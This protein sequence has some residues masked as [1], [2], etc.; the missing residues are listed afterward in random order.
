[1][2][3]KSQKAVPCRRC[4]HR[5]CWN[6]PLGNWPPGWPSLSVARKLRNNLHLEG[7][8]DSRIL[9]LKDPG[10][11]KLRMVSWNLN[12]PTRLGGD[13]TPQ[14]HPLTFG[15][16]SNAPSK[17]GHVAGVVFYVGKGFLK[18][19]VRVALFFSRI[20][21]FIYCMEIF[22][23]ILCLYLYLQLICCHC[24]LGII[25]RTSA[26]KKGRHFKGQKP[27]AFSIF[28]VLHADTWK[29]FGMIFWI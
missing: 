18:K 3:S 16:W 25:R 9:T 2:H 10:S 11:P 13:W 21:C 5:K 17:G 1:M 6:W 4:K 23:E 26:N 22:I 27:S 14:S 24:Q 15:D 29:L 12:F 8:G 19:S 28:T 20:V 7:G